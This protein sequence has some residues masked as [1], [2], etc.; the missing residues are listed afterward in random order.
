MG[1]HTK[2]QP[3][4]KSTCVLGDPGCLDLLGPFKQLTQMHPFPFLPIERA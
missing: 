1:E 4:L 3:P 2:R